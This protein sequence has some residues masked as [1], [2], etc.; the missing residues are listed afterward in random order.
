MKI[1]Y[2]QRLGP[3]DKILTMLGRRY[4]WLMNLV[5][6]QVYISPGVRWLGYSWEDQAGNTESHGP[7][8]SVSSSFRSLHLFMPF[9]G[10]KGKRSNGTGLK[11]LYS[12]FFACFL[13]VAIGSVLNTP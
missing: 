3:I 11:A 6:Y 1:S 7:S 12:N 5:G 10:F 8:L 4:F 2:M 9:L 13:T